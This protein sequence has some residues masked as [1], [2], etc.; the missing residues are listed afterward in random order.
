VEQEHYEQSF[1]AYRQG[2]HSTCA[3]Y[4]GCH[5]LT[6]EQFKALISDVLYAADSR[7]IDWKAIH[8][9][10]CYIKVLISDGTNQERTYALENCESGDLNTL[11]TILTGFNE[12]N[13]LSLIIPEISGNVSCWDL[14]VP[15]LIDFKECDMSSVTHYPC[16][17]TWMQRYEGLESPSH[18]R[19]CSALPEHMQ[20][21]DKDYQDVD[22]ARNTDYG[23]GWIFVNE[24]GRSA[25]DINDL[26]E[27]QPQGYFLP[28]YNMK[29]LRWNEVLVQRMSQ[30]GVTAGAASRVRGLKMMEQV[31]VSSLTIIMCTA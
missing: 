16:G 17:P 26:S 11:A 25:Q 20:Y 21:S 13:Y 3:E 10:A 2:L 28:S 9:I 31:C 15:P 8:K 30:T 12:T 24:L 14:D 4:Q 6:E 1:C 18:C 23:G 5:I 29:G 7:K 27:I 22:H 19:E